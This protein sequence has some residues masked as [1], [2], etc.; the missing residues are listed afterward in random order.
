MK[1]FSIVSCLL[2]M[3]SAGLLQAQTQ[4]AP[5]AGTSGF[6]ADWKQQLDDV[7]KK[8]L[9]LAEAVPAEKYTWR[10]AEG[11]RSFSEVFVHIAGGNY[12]LPTF[13]GVNPPAGFKRDAEKTVTDKAKVIEL[14]KQSFDHLRAAF[15]KLQDAEMDKTV[16]FFGTKMTLRGIYLSTVGHVNEH[17]GQSIAYA[18]INGV[19]PPWSAGGSN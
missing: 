2:L 16:D 17:L 19:V 4:T 6:R 8:A 3:L 11:V 18:R 13:A 7:Q 1:R 12:F 14:M 5:A 15:D 10:P 9:D